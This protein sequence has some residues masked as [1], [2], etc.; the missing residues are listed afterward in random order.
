MVSGGEFFQTAAFCQNSEG[1]IVMSDWR[2]QGQE[3]YLKGRSLVLKKYQKYRHDWDHDHCEFC[4]RKISER[5]E[6][7]NVGY[8]TTDDY[9][10]VC[11]DCFKEFAA[12][13]DW[14]ALP[15]ETGVS[16]DTN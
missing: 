10:W 7:L 14:Q 13:F 2:L 4:G 6:D 1:D 11:E 3:R 15:G 16:G 9:Y 5:P 8:A 12:L